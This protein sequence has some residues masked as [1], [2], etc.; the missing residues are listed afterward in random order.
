MFPLGGMK[1]KEVRE[2]AKQ[3][4]LVN[5]D[6]KSTSGICFIEQKS[7]R[8]F[9]TNYIQDK[10]GYIQTLDKVIIGEHRG[11]TSLHDRPKKRAWNRW[12]EKLSK[13]TLVCR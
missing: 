8:D 4:N 12:I 10:P 1:K 11:L 13:F 3:Y 2:V 6:K 7:F 5:S 9:I